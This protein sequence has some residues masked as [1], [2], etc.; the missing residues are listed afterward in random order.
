MTESQEEIVEE[1]EVVPLRNC[2]IE[3]GVQ[4]SALGECDQLKE[5]IIEVYIEIPARRGRFACW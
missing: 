3:A 1:A 2:Y 4:R 5:K